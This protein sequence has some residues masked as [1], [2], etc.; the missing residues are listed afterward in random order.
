MQAHFKI[1]NA[2]RTDCAGLLLLAGTL[3]FAGC[4]ANGG[5]SVA[6]SM[7]YKSAAH[8][9]IPSRMQ[10]VP[11]PQT[12]GQYAWAGLIKVG[13]LLYGTTY[14]GGTSG[15][16]VVYQITTGGIETP[17]H[18]FTGSPDGA[19]PDGALL[20]FGSCCAYGTTANGGT[21]NAGTVFIQKLSP[22]GGDGVIHS[23]TGTDGSAPDDKLI[24]IGGVLYGTT[25]TGGAN[26]VGTVFKL[27]TS[28]TLTTLHSFNSTD[29]AY[30]Y[31]GLIQVGGY[32]YGT[33][34][35]GGANSVGTVF[36]N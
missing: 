8:V 6:P 36:R 35:G 17:I 12:T 15:L 9:L 29:G 24:K 2:A 1:Q 33:A 26:G 27:T 7:P 18:S 34:L 19:L 28:G 11:P 14:D 21:S 22:G 20:K 10:P 4:A 30:P 25:Y 23:F 32:L 5:S 31:A 13:P 16:G 3:A